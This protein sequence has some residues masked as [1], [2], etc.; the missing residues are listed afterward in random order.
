MENNKSTI[1]E[2]LDHIRNSINQKMKHRVTMI[3]LFYWI[4]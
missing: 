2:E 1:N 4:K 3:T